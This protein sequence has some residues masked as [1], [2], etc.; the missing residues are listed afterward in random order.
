M[1]DDRFS[2]AARAV[3]ARCA[4]RRNTVDKLDL[5]DRRHL[6]R[7]VLL[8]HRAAFEKD[9]RDDVVATTYV[10]EQLGEQIASALRRIPEMMVWVDDR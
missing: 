4:H 9:R 3:S 1:A 5:A 7:A 8:V 6:G 10:V 2:D